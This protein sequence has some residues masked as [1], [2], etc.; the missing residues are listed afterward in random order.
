MDNDSLFY[1]VM[2]ADG[3]AIEPFDGGGDAPTDTTADPPP[4]TGGDL[5]DDGPPPLSDEGG[6]DLS[7]FSDDGGGDDMGG[8][9]DDGG[10]GSGD[11]SDGDN[12]NDEKLSEKANNILNQELYKKMVMRNKEIEDT[13][14]SIRD[15]AGALPYDIVKTNEDSLN[16]LKTALSRG[17]DYVIH[18][19]VDAGYGENLLFAKKL[20]ATYT[21]LLNRIDANLKKVKNDN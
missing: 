9:G 5:G 13:L 1:L 10:N 11:D 14:K 17:Q 16:H 12:K 18:D 15:L 7:S 8:F 6:D 19:F 2:E 3:D 4:D 21:I 20:D